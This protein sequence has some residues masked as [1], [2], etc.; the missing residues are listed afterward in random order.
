MNISFIDHSSLLLKK[1]R[2][3]ATFKMKSIAILIFML[4]KSCKNK[5]RPEIL[6]KTLVRG[7]INPIEALCKISGRELTYSFN[8]S[9]IINSLIIFIL[10]L[11]WN[12]NIFRLPKC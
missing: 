5:F 3:F 7:I 6:F 1:A 2:H 8:K 11:N 9:E 10:V 12:F 4:E